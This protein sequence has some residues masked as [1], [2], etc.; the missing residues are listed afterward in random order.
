[1]GLEILTAHQRVLLD[2]I[3]DAQRITDRFTLSGGTALAAFYYNH[4]DS[5]DLDFFSLEEVNAEAITVFLRSAQGA[6]GY[7]AIDLQSSFNR[8]LAFLQFT[9]GSVLKAEFTYFP[10]TPLAEGKR[11]GTLRVE[12]ALDLAAN[13]LFTIYQKP[14]ARDFIDLYLLQSRE[15]Y[16]LDNLRAA[17]RAKFDVH[18]DPLQLGTKFLKAKELADLPRMRIALPEDEWRSFFV[19]AARGLGPSVLAA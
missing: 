9:D 1:M 15:R 13:K 7:D 19:D 14:R 2:R 6:I 16:T 17:V 12:S 10:F 11:Y 3:R 5:E 8:N 18:V 4:R